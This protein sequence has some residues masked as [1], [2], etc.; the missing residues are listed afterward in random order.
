LSFLNDPGE[1]CAGYWTRRRELIRCT[2]EASRP[3]AH[4]DA[5]P[6]GLHPLAEN[7][8]RHGCRYG[9][10]CDVHSYANVSEGVTAGC[11]YWGLTGTGRFPSF[12]H[13]AEQRNANRAADRARNITA[14]FIR[15]TLK[16]Y[17]DD[18]TGND[19]L[20]FH[21]ALRKRGCGD[22]TI[23]NKHARLKSWLLFAGTPFPL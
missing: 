23:A 12:I 22:R 17:L 5:G 8:V 20:K 15:E 16:A 11:S 9:V 14:E 4:V 21:A 10:A 3:E 6:D 19:V 13:D 7:L 18:V 2:V 1:E